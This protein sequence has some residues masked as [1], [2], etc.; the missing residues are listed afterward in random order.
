[1]EQVDTFDE[2]QHQHDA[3]GA[4]FD[5]IAPVLGNF[6]CG[7]SGRRLRIEEGDAV[8]TDGERIVLPPLIAALPDLD[9]NFQLAKIT[10][11][12]LWAQT[13]FGSLRIDHA[14]ITAAQPDP[15]AAAETPPELEVT[16]RD[17]NGRLDFDITLD[18]API[19]PPDGVRQLLTSVYLDF[20]EIPPEYLTP[21]GDGEYDPNLVFDQPEDP[22]AVW[23][24]TYH[25][26]GAEREDRHPGPR[27]L[28]SRHARQACRRGQAPAQ[29][30]RGAARRKPPRQAADP[31]RRNR[32][33]CPDRGAGRCEGRPRN[34]RPPVR[35]PAPRRAQHRGGVSG[36]HE[37]LDQ[38]VDQRGRARGAD[39]AVRGAGTLGRPLRDLRLFRDHAQAL[40]TVPHQ[41]LRR[42]LRRRGEGAHR[43]H[44]PA[45]DLRCVT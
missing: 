25:V 37:R 13:R 44:P 15:Q 32:P 23:Q 14:A 19:A 40:R 4:L 8:W 38:G 9:D 16:P 17:E 39:P 10:V 22:D 20:G 6:V 12:L 34:E 30:I 35:A 45:W 3:A 24:G 18:D 1:M 21:A 41:D 7:L 28:L 26:K 36:R 33:R 31:G 27:Q 43:R 5:D 42:A 2:A 11:A 29:E